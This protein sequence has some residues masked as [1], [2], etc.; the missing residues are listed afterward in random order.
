M[1]RFYRQPQEV[2][3]MDPV[4]LSYW[5]T[6]PGKVR[7]QLLESRITVSSLGELKMLEARLGEP[8]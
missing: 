6:M 1:E 4:L 5:D 2:V 8:R 3:G 7:L